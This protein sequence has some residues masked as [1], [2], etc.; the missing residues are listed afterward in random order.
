[1]TKK[2]YIQALNI[3]VFPYE[4]STY[5]QQEFPT[6]DKFTNRKDVIQSLLTVLADDQNRDI[7]VIMAGYTEQMLKMMEM[8]PGLSSRFPRSNHYVFDDYTPDDPSLRH[9][10]TPLP[11]PSHNPAPYPRL[12]C[13][14]D[15]YGYEIS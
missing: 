8:N 11:G 6:L 14:N 15:G 10:S 7:M 1:M 9:P 2:N 3:Q 12:Y 4:H 13:I 5:Y